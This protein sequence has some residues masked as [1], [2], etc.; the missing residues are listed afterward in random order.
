MASVDVLVFHALP[1]QDALWLGPY[2]GGDLYSPVR[3]R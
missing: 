1:P 2:D 3:P